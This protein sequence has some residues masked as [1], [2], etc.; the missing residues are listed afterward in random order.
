MKLFLII[1]YAMFV[2]IPA[3]YTQALINKLGIR[4]ENYC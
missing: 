1:I 2:L 4:D 3:L